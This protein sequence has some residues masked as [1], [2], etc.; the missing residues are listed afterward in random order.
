ML[1]CTYQHHRYTNLKD[2]NDY[3]YEFNPCYG[4]G[5]GTSGCRS[6][7]AVSS[8]VCLCVHLHTAK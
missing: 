7:T 2:P 6:N 3:T 4:F 5:Y 8:T 1:F